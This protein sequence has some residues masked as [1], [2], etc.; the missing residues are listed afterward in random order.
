ME[1]LSTSNLVFSESKKTATAC[2][3]EHDYAMSGQYE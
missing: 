2:N 3:F 1:V